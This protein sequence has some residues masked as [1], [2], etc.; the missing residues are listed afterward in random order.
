MADGLTPDPTIS[1]PPPELSPEQAAEVRGPEAWDRFRNSF[2]AFWASVRLAVVLIMAIAIASTIGTIV[3]QGGPED[4]LALE[5]MSLRTREFLISIQAYNVYYSAW[6]LTLLGLFFLNL[7]VCTYVRVWPRLKFAL[8]RPRDLPLPARD[9]MPDQVRF[10]TSSADQIAELLRRKG[11]RVFPARE[12]YVADRHRMF[13]FAA[14]VVHLGLFMILI[15]GIT[16][17]LTGYK[18]SFPL[19]PGESMPARKAWE[20]ARTRGR[21]TPLPDDFKIR[22][23]KF[24]TTRYPNGTVKQFYSTLSVVEGDKPVLTRTIK[25]NEPLEYKGTTY[26]QSFYGIGAERLTVAR[27]IESRVILANQASSLK[28]QGFITQRFELGGRQVFGYH[29][30]K[31]DHFEVL[32]FP[33]LGYVGDMAPGQPLLAGPHKVEVKRVMA[34]PGVASVRLTVAGKPLVVPVESASRFKMQGYITR[35]LVFGDRKVFLF[36]PGPDLPIQVVDLDSIASLGDVAPGKSRQFG[37]VTVRFGGTV[38]D[39]AGGGPIATELVIDGQTQVLRMVELEKTGFRVEGA[40]SDPVEIGGREVV[41]MQASEPPGSPLWIMDAREGTA[42]AVMRPGEKSRLGIT[43]VRWEGPVWF[44]G[45]QTKTDPGL[46]VIY[47]GFLIVVVGTLMGLFNH[48]QL[49]ITA[50]E[51]GCRLGAKV[52]RGRH[53]FRRHL[54]RLFHPLGGT[55]LEPAPVGKGTPA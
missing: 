54:G 36:V 41:L 12:G 5:E 29:T 45:L 10:D 8:S 33:M 39:P 25:V 4:V 30:G 23:D 35:Q 38:P 37:G 19:L 16:A 46:P 50:Q 20:D 42:L 7:A 13:R 32:T 3:P 15:G 53:T 26:Y 49:W 34:R 21:L 28:L 43:Q 9:H 44:S 47:A 51:Q 1:A 17:G 55:L 27:G 2:V 22:L 14:M 6:Y 11:Y 31:G 40:A 52:N 48:E 24:W 18:H